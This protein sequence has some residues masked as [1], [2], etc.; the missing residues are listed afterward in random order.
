MKTAFWLLTLLRLLHRNLWTDSQSD[1]P[2]GL[3]TSYTIEVALLVG[4]RQAQ[5][6]S[7]AGPSR[8]LV[9]EQIVGSPPISR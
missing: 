2:C 5:R 8:R 1:G 7:N 6:W 9:H 3:Y 4:A